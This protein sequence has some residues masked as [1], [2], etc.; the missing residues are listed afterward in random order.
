MNYIF[1]FEDTLF[2]RQVGVNNLRIYFVIKKRVICLLGV[3]KLKND[4]ILSYIS[5]ADITYF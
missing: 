3:L 1:S 2:L 5:V 4:G